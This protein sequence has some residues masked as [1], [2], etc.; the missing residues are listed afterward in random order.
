MKKITSQSERAVVARLMY[1][2]KAVGCTI[3][4]TQQFRPSRQAL[5]LPDL[6]LVHPRLGGFWH[7]AKRPGGRQTPVQRAFQATVEEAGVDYVLGGV[8]EAMAYLERR[9][10]V[11]NRFL[12]NPWGH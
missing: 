8:E 4:S 1:A 10:L 6:Y 3:Y 5:G 12:C 9:G 2:Y 11:I 7:E